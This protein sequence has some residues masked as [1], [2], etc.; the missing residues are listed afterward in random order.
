MIAETR[1]TPAD[2]G[3]SG[4]E[5]NSILQVILAEKRTAMSVLRTGIAVLVLPM[6][7][8]SFLVVTSGFYDILHV[9]YLVFPLLAIAAA[10]VVLSAYLILR[11]ILQLH[12][13]DRSLKELKRQHPQLVEILD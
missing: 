8:I 4:A 5:I 13:C 3:R 12:F 9:N 2:L 6:S 10:L 1:K 7:V 11:A